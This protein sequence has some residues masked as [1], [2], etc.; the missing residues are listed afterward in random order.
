MDELIQKWK[1]CKYFSA[2]DVR[3][4]YHNIRIK[5]GD[6]WK[7][8]FIMNRGLY[9]SLVMTFGLTNAPFYFPGLYTPI[10][11]SFTALMHGLNP[12]HHRLSD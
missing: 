7:T 8:A 2:M 9:K 1:G 6:E 5:E 4:G 11:P 3:S 10:C 12:V